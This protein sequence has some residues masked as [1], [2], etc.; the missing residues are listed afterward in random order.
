MAHAKV[1]NTL[2]AKYDLKHKPLFRPNSDLSFGLY[3]FLLIPT[4]GSSLDLS[5]PLSLS[6][7]RKKSMNIKH[8]Y[9][10]RKNNN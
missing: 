2:L 1:F 10:Q 8:N 6:L 9:M 4:Q 7:S 5:P 3:P